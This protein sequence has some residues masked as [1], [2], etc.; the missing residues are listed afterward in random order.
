M[1]AR[2]SEAGGG[3]A[4][5][6][7]CDG[8][9]LHRNCGRQPVAEND[10]QT[11]RAVLLSMFATGAVYHRLALASPVPVLSVIVPQTYSF[12]FCSPSPPRFVSAMPPCSATLRGGRGSRG[13]GGGGFKNGLY[14]SPEVVVVLDV[15][16]DKLDA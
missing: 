16:L 13:G 3:G 15:V 11:L 4:G 2:H 7:C 10:E 1:T 8:F 9:I 14:Q 6:D 5:E 12:L